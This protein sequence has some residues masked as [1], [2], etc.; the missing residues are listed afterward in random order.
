MNTVLCSI[1][2]RGHNIQK[3]LCG[4]ER[5]QFQSLLK[6]K[7]A[8]LIGCRVTSVQSDICMNTGIKWK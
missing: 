6:Q 5:E 3:A 7:F 4:I 2:S 8:D 1:H